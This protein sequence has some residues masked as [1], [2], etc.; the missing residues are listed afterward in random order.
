MLATAQAAKTDLRS[1]AQKGV[2]KESGIAAHASVRGQN[3]LAE[4]PDV[5]LTNDCLKQ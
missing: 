1:L 3:M 5:V 2:I 4:V